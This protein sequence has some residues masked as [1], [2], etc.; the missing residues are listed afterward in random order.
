MLWIDYD[1]LPVENSQVASRS[2]AMQ[3]NSVGH[4]YRII[5]DSLDLSYGLLDTSRR[6]RTHSFFVTANNWSQLR[7]SSSCLV[8][9][10]T[11]TSVDRLF[12]IGKQA[13]TWTGP[14]SVAV[15]APGEDYTIASAMITVLRGCFPGVRQRVTFHLTYPTVLPPQGMEIKGQAGKYSCTDDLEAI[16]KDL[17]SKFRSESLIKTLNLSRYPQNLLRNIAR[18]GCHNEYAF[19]PDVDMISN[20]D[21]SD[22]LNEFLGTTEIKNCRNC[23]FIVPVYEIHERVTENP[24]NKTDLLELLKKGEAQQFHRRVFAQNQANSKLDDWEEKGMTDKLQVYYNELDYLQSLSTI[25][26]DCLP[27]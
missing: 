10:S 13:E 3:E 2:N 17:V 15:F 4:D 20:P 9:L 5:Y 14:M 25:L 24:A 11:Q 18:Q 22:H 6:Y 23:A 16:N 19:T 27:L 8:C 1:K 21:M 12:W 7:E 26:R